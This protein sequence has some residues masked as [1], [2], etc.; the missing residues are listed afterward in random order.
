MPFRT[1]TLPLLVALALSQS[2][3]A[4][5]VFLKNGDRI[6]GKV[7]TMHKSALKFKT[8]Y[9]EITIPWSDIKNLSSDQSIT[10]EL[11]DGSQLKGQLIQSAQGPSIKNPNL[12]SAIPLSLDNISAINPPTVSNDAVITGGV[13]FGGSKSSGNTDNQA[14]H[15]DVEMVARAGNNKFSAGAEYNQVANDGKESKNDFHI[16]SQ[17]DHYFMPKWYSSLFTNFTKDRFQDLKFRSTFGAGVG[18]EVWDTKR[19]FL[20][21]EA[22]AAY[23]IEDFNT[24]T[25]REFIAGRWGVKYHYWVLEDRLKFFHDHEGLASFEDFSDV[26]VRSHTGFKL[27]VYQG[28]ELLAQFD[29]DY[30]TKPAK[31]KKK[32]DTQYIV[33]AGYSW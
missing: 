20:S 24:G 25:D 6:S 16:Y 32:S 9:S 1:K 5:T 2:V 11:T 12:A 17:Y 23:T 28:F 33:G 30:D 21:V 14:F 31:G 10:V 8:P 26:L 7:T 19:S 22:G 27:P 4:D 3:S 13:H 18:H 29:F 15:A